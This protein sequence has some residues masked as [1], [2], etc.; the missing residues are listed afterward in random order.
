MRTRACALAAIVLLCSSA[1]APVSAEPN[2]IGA[3][4]G[5]TV[6]KVHATSV[7]QTFDSENRIGFAGTAFLSMEWGSWGIQPEISYVQKGAKEL[8]LDYLEVAALGKFGLVI[9]P[10]LTGHLFAGAG[11]DYEVD[12][13]SKIPASTEELDWAGIFGFDAVIDMDRFVLVGD[14]RYSMGLA[15]VN[16]TSTVIKEAKNRAWTLTAG[17]GYKF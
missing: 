7:S 13:T 1:L 15:E 5:V 2:I 11:V 4:A 10:N 6:S 16:S 9:L 17:A 12:S 14:A 8:A 3:R